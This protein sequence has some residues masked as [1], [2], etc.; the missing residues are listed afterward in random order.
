M[1]RKP[2]IAIA[3]VTL[4]FVKGDFA[5]ISHVLW[6]VSFNPALTEELVKRLEDG[7][8]AALKDVRWYTVLP[9]RLS[10]GEDVEGFACNSAWLSFWLP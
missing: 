8:L 9:W 2:G 7:R 4:V 3:S 6:A 10:T 5:C 1:P